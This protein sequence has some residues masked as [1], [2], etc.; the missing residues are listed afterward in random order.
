VVGFEELWDARPLTEPQVNLGPSDSSLK[1]VLDRIRQ[2][3]P[4]YK[5]DLLEGGLVHVYPAH[6]TADPLGSLDIRL[7]EFFLP[8]G[9]CI[10]PQI[11]SHGQLLCRSFT[12]E[13]SEYL[14]RK[15]P[16]WN[17][18]HGSQ[19]FDIVGD[20]MGDWANYNSAATRLVL[21]EGQRY[22]STGL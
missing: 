12:P 8:P 3:N 21:R 22:C 19:P 9:D 13:L 18:K 10:P 5:L 4:Q 2:A 17:Q 15:K 7:S 11:N 16:E 14:S 6:G 20:S 1:H